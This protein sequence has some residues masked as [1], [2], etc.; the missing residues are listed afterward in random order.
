LAR[1]LQEILHIQLDMESKTVPL[2]KQL[3]Q[4]IAKQIILKAIKADTILPASRKLAQQLNLSR[5]T[6]QKAYTQ[7]IMEGYLST[8]QGSGI[9]VNK[10]IPDDYCQVQNLSNKP[11][12]TEPP[13][14]DTQLSDDFAPGIPDL[15][16]FPYKIWTRMCN[17]VNRMEYRTLLHSNHPDG[18]PGFKNI[19]RDY[20]H[21]ARGIQCD[22]EQIII[23]S[24][25][26]EAINLTMRVML[27]QNKNI[28]IENPGY[29]GAYH[30]AKSCHAHC[31]P[32]PVEDDGIDIN[33]VKSL[34][35]Q[36]SLLYITP[37]HQYP[38]GAT[39]PI[40]KRLALLQWAD[41]QKSY[42]IEDDYDSEYHYKAQ[43]LPA[44]QGL[45]PDSRVIYIGTMSKVLF[46]SLRLG[47]VI[48]P[49][50]LLLQFKKMK[51]FGFGSTAL[52]NQ[53]V[54]HH[55]I[56]E[57]HFNR[58]IKTMRLHYAKKLEAITQA[59]KSILPKYITLYANSIGLHITLEIADC[60]ACMHCA[61][62]VLT[63]SSEVPK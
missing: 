34:S 46:P 23:T 62:E 57:G 27:D 11:I 29:H 44:L 60:S 15:E 49:K 32:I 16:A 50:T 17:Q 13:I 63:K 1:Q 38:L 53:R 56:S 55:F 61:V 48:T 40:A 10:G 35:R 52:F 8:R 41:S 45:Q 5:N 30:A 33:Y 47:Y 18:D 51:Q 42:I 3:Y 36:P 22:L 20:L 43:P 25:A 37:S 24:G 12:I 9:Y 28:A 7:L 31:I 54:A 21:Y 39:L 2:Y 26:Q 59:C 6:V 19:L 14:S 4:T 58:H